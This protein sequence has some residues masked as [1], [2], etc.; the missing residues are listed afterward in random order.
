M[1]TLLIEIN[2]KAHKLLI[3]RAE[4]NKRSTRAEASMIIETE[5]KKDEK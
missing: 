5:V 3:T 1:K 4:K 2:D